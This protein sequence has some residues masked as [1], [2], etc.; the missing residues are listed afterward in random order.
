MSRLEGGYG[1]SHSTGTF[2]SLR[3]G[4]MPWSVVAVFFVA[5]AAY[6][7][8]QDVNVH[9]EPRDKTTAPADSS[10]APPS[11]APAK[12]KDANARSDVNSGL[13]AR[14]AGKPIIKTVDLVLVNVTV[15]DD[16]NRIVT[17]LEKENFAV[18]DGGEVMEVRHFSSEDA[19]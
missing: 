8:A 6:A 17:G 5:F 12:D 10:H 1:I 16:W 9:I 18:S 2:R 11:P 4:L 13:A 3:V 14:P 7:V 19:P 15:T